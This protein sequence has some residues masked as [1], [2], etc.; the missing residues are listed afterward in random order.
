MMPN[1]LK[2]LELFTR[3]LGHLLGSGVPLVVSLDIIAAETAEPEFVTVIRNIAGMIRGGQRFS[4]GLAAHAGV[5]SASYVGMAKAG[6]NAGTLD[7]MLVKIADGLRDGLVAPGDGDLSAPALADDR[8]EELVMELLR[9][10]TV[11]K[12]SDLHLVPLIDGVLV[13]HRVDGCLREVRQLERNLGRPLV[14]RLKGMAQC[15]V[16]ETRLPQDGR[17]VLDIDGTQYDLRVGFAP[18]PLGEKITV[19][20][21]NRETITL[22]PARLVPDAHDRAWFDEIARLSHGLVIFSGPTGSGKTSTVY[23]VLDTIRQRSGAAI[24]TVEDPVELFIR[25]AMQIRT[26][27][28]IGLDFPAAINTVLRHDP[29][30]VYISEI[31]DG[32]VL[33]Q[34]VKIAVTG[35]LTFACMHGADVLDTWRRLLAAPVAGHLLASAMSAVVNQVLVRRVCQHCARPAGDATTADDRRVF[36]L[37]KTD[38][39]KLRAG[40]GCDQCNHSGYRGRV[41]IY[42]CHRPSRAFKDTL[43]GKDMAK[44]TEAL[45]R[46][47]F[48]TL[49]EAAR[50]LLL[51]G[52]TTLAEICRVMQPDE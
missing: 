8:S 15:D 50:E 14:A 41:A 11:E 24:A 52:T 12:A 21:I 40:E 26:M 25:G 5:F 46:E 43:I 30:V 17:I 44:V 20:I 48:R 36:N 33:G 3:K 10:A 22:D 45:A 23:S 28:W 7:H 49:R 37:R 42:A 9:A 27:P 2:K 32:D 16:G 51:A 18:T 34:A 29:D 31:R 1:P 6:E 4:D 19:R 35:H 47:K 39:A 13:Q 38:L